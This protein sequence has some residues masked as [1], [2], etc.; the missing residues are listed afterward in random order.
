MCKCYAE[1][2]AMILRG[3]DVDKI[4]E[5]VQKINSVHFDSVGYVT[6]CPLDTARRAE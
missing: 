1:T 4:A 5:Q 6:P 3:E 2:N